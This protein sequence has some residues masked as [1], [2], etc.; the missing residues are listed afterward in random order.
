MKSIKLAKASLELFLTDLHFPTEDPQVWNLITQVAKAVKPN[1]VWFNGD[2]MD[3]DSV[4]SFMSKPEAKLNLHK[5]IKHGRVKLQQMRDLCPDADMY[6]KMGNHD[7]RLQKFLWS[8]APELSGLEEL[9]LPSLLH[10]KDAEIK[11]VP[12]DEKVM[13][14]ELFHLHGHEVPTGNIYPARAMLARANA[15][16]IFGHRHRFTVAYQNDLSGKVHISW[17][18]GCGQKLNVDYDLNVQWQQGF[19][20]NEYTKEGLFHINPVEVF[21]DKGK[22]CCMVYGKL[23]TA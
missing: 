20:L 11:F 18:I 23:Y 19:A 9:E 22:K 15:N 10:L 17:S 2:A 4:S 21:Q 14:G 3:F 12:E 6:F 1:I 13:I 16:V 5:D 7:V 8:K